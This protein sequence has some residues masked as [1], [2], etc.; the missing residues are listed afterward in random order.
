MSQI[1]IEFLSSRNY[2]IIAKVML[3]LG[4]IMLSVSLL[5]R[6]QSLQT[7]E[8]NQKELSYLS[9]KIADRHQENQLQLD[10]LHHPN[11][12]EIFSS[13]K[14]PWGRLLDALYSFPSAV[15]RVESFSTEQGRGMYTVLGSAANFSAVR[16]YV[17]SLEEREEVNGVTILSISAEASPEN[18][19]RFQL[20]LTGRKCNDSC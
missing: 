3:L 7:Y 20:S 12:Q 11:F 14:L 2:Q 9:Q 13:F 15:I 8:I 19:V 17:E 5:W 10:L 6:D 1:K 18:N 16:E 4:A